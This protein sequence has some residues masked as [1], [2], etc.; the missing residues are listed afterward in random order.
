MTKLAIITGANGALGKEYLKYFS[1]KKNYSVIGWSKNE[2]KN[3][4]KNI[5]YL[6]GDLLDKTRIKYEM[7]K[8][9]LKNFSKIIFIHPVGK[10][11]FEL[12][13]TK[14][15]NKEEI[16]S[17]IFRSNV[18]TFLNTADTILKSA[19]KKTKLMFCAFGSISDKYKIPFWKSYS[20][21]K[22]E[23]K[24]LIKNLSYDNAIRGVFV[25]ISSTL[26]HNEKNLRPFADTTYWLKPHEIVDKTIQEI[27]YGKLPFIELEIFK[28][29]PGFDKS[30]YLDYKSIY[31]K[32]KKEMGK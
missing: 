8:I 31:Q 2:P 21:S 25:N 7:S 28:S 30:Y 12:K 16:N 27:I 17:E 22:K 5:T 15:E 3:K 4:I 1:D 11:R 24:K 19:N 10:F 6:T 29:K 13:N 32:W 14:D 23:L 20:S 26:T 9:E 18:M